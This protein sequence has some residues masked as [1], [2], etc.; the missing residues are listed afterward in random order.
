MIDPSVSVSGI[1]YFTR[2]NNIA[3]V[4]GRFGMYEE[5]IVSGATVDSQADNASTLGRGQCWR[6]LGGRG[7]A[8]DRR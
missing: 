2:A 6:D 4:T 5:T 7:G 1:Y 3:S 8:L